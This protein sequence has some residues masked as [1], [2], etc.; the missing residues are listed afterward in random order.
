MKIWIDTETTGLNRWKHGI[1][2]LAFLI[3]K[4]EEVQYEEVLYSNPIGKQIDKEALKI[5]GT[6]EAQLAQYD[7]WPL[8]AIRFTEFL[9][10]QVDKYNPLD[11]L[12]PCGYNVD[13]DLGML[14]GNWPDKY[15]GSFFARP[16][17]EVMTY[18]AEEVSRGLKLKS[19]SLEEVC[20]HFEIPLEAHN[21]L[22]DIKA[23]RALYY[24]LKGKNSG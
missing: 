10:T 24:K 21:A 6:T 5:H 14:R 12:V 23:T 18:V 20:K 15:F 9:G 1:V 13:F 2:Q 3:E 16:T 22:A 11:K 19:Y 7:P 4:D 8:V 17:I